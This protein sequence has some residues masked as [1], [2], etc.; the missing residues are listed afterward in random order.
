MTLCSD[1]RV[2]DI[3]LF[4]SSGITLWIHQLWTMAQGLD[5]GNNGSSIWIMW[6]V[7]YVWSFTHE[8]RQLKRFYLAVLHGK[9]GDPEHTWST[10]SHYTLWREFQSRTQALL[11]ICF[12]IHI[13]TLSLGTSIGKSTH[14]GNLK[15]LFSSHAQWP[16]P[17]QFHRNK[18]NSGGTVPLSTCNLWFL[19]QPSV[20]NGLAVAFMLVCCLNWL[21]HTLKLGSLQLSSAP[22][23]IY[24]YQR[25]IQKG[26]VGCLNMSTHST[27]IRFNWGK[28]NPYRSRDHIHFK[29]WTGNVASGAGG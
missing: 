2:N 24:C 11:A 15:T 5:K 6:M 16:R 27:G 26:Q 9:K 12:L 20:A 22:D 25:N 21:H 13:C 7:A 19:L 29:Y 1:L 28:M 17:M 23:S 18:W 3:Y 14:G 10:L 8:H 4:M